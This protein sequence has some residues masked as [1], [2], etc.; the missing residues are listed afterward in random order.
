M[1]SRNWLQMILLDEIDF[2]VYFFPI[3]RT[4]ISNW[5]YA[6]LNFYE[7]PGSTLY[8]YQLSDELD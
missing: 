2:K 5:I 6:I 4:G 3:F 1:V 8:D 7:S